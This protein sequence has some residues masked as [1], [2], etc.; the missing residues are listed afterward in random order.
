[1]SE[2][3]ET[4]KGYLHELGYAI[5]Q[6][7]PAEELVILNDEDQGISNLIIDCE[8]PIL[9]VEQIIMPVPDR[10]NTETFFKRLLQINRTTLYKKLKRYGLDADPMARSTQTA[11]T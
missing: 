11:N 2:Y 7:N 3:F 1:M 8:D 5:D 4:V 6:E 10:G 9:V